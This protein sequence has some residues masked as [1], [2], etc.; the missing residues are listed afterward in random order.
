MRKIWYY[1][2]L[3]K[4]YLRIGVLCTTQYPADAVIMLVSMLLREASAFIG[5]LTITSVAGGLGDWGVYEICLMFSMCAIIEAI[6]QAFFDSVW[7][8]SSMVRRGQMDV[9]LVRPASVF[10]QV[11][12]Q[13]IQFQAVFSMTIY[14][15]IM[16]FSLVKLHVHFG[17]GLLFFLLEYLVCAT[18]VNSGVYLIFNSLNFW[19]V[20][21]KDI[22][23]VVQ[24][25][26]EFAKYPLS[27][28]PVMVRTFFTYVIPFGILG[29]YPAAYL[30][31]KAGNE[32]I[33]MMPLLASVVVAA[34]SFV[35]RIGLNSY[36]STGT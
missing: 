29:Y 3:W 8:I 36:N 21:G 4:Q 7:S 1:F 5:I 30:T 14:A 32:V 11:I 18:A 33:W 23:E 13:R 9:F 22:A 20:Q 27:V 28:F 31:G 24:T 17:I 25:C 15:G 34:A 19:I 2:R 26:R 12:G 35:W 10:F 16:V 6:G